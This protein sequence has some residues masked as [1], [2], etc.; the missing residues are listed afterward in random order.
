MGKGF[1]RSALLLEWPEDSEFSGLEIRMKR[2]T[3]GQ[4]M[5]IEKLSDLRKSDDTEETERAMVELLDLLGKGLLGWN[6]EAE[7]EIERPD[8]TTTVVDVPVPAERGSLDDLDIDMVMAWVRA[9]ARAAAAVPLASPPSSPIGE[10]APPDEEWASYLQ[11]SQ[12]SLP[13]PV[14]S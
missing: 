14:S 10:P 1:K 9:W 6:L 5:R 2:V 3:V 12:E 8:G 13:E 4:L 7:Q 11:Q